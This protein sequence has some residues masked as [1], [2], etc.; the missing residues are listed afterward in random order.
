[1]MTDPTAHELNELHD[2]PKKGC[3][4]RIPFEQMA[5]KKHWYALPPDLRKRINWAWRTGN[6]SATIHARRD[7][8][9]ILNGAAQ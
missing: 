5:C 3:P 2:C 1:M 6:V 9:T 8:E 7:V 4:T